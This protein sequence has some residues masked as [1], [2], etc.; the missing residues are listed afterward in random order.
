MP[1]QKTVCPHC[2]KTVEF[3][4]TSV[5]RSRDC[6]ECGKPILLQL[7]SKGAGQKRKALLMPSIETSE[8]K[9]DKPEPTTVEPKV[10]EGDIRRRM[11]HDPEVQTS[12]RAMAWGGGVVLALILLVTLGSYFHIIDAIAGRITKPPITDNND[13]EVQSVANKSPSVAKQ[14]KTPEELEKQLSIQRLLRKGGAVLEPEMPKDPL[15]DGELSLATNAAQAFLRAPNVEERLKHIRDRSLLEGKIRDYYV[16][17]PDGPILF[18]HIEAKDINPDASLTYTLAVVM[19]KGDKR[20]LVVGKAKSGTYVADWASFVCYHEMEWAELKSRKPT[21]P[22]LIR[23]LASSDT[24]FNH[25]FT[26]KKRLLCVKLLDPTQIE[27]TPIYA[28]IERA[29]ILGR[30]L[31]FVLEEMPGRAVPVALRI[32]Y[33]ENADTDNQVIITD[34]VAKGWIVRGR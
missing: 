4:V 9:L 21:A 31:E 8:E 19:L 3:N 13:A 2:E 33:P 16:K 34:L 1:L 25:N 11:M 14:Q 5:T 30:S 32:K 24:F 7:S 6:P 17:H 20:N 18:D 22:V 28:Y 10:L 15:V 26:D 29:T 12:M 27:A 23:V